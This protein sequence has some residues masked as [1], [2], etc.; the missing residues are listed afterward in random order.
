MG[1]GLTGQGG[2]HA[3]NLAVVERKR[4]KGFAMSLHLGMAETTARGNAITLLRVIQG[5]VQVIAS[6]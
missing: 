2:L 5:D 3:R 4:E 1:S 6:L